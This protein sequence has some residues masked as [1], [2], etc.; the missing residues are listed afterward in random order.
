VN[1]R[2]QV[3]HPVTEMTT[4]LDLVRLQIEI[5][6]GKALPM[7]QE[8]VQ[9]EGHAIEARLYAEDPHNDF[10]P[11]TG[12]ILEW[13]APES[14]DGLRVDTGVT[15]GTEIGIHYDPMLAK[16]IACGKDRDAARYKLRHGLE[17]LFVAGVRTNRDFLLRVISD[18]AF[19]NGNYHTQ[20]I[21][22]RQTELTK[23]ESRNDDCIAASVLALYLMQQRQTQ[24]PIL[25]QIPVGFRNNPFRDPTVKLQIGT[26]TFEISCRL[27]GD[28]AFTMSTQDW[29]ANVRLVSFEA[30][31]I[32]VTIDDVFRTFRIGIAGEEYYV[33][34]QSTS[35]IVRR[36]SRY[37]QSNATSEHESAYA[38]MPGQVLKF[39]LR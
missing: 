29:Q 5:A 13:D 37:P 24:S 3:E 7:A 18:S 39:W 36:L 31:R 15:N 16:F 20:L 38:P 22:S 8:Q 11:A 4:G 9:Q 12:T 33:Q 1:T 27:A 17:R 26:Q 2:L 21:D 19:V 23:Q 28:D 30:E 35:R 6:E 14:I 10:L 34:H 25:P 32:S